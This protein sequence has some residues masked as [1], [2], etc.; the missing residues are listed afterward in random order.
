MWISKQAF[1]KKSPQCA[2]N[3]RGPQEILIELDPAV[4][5]SHLSARAD[6]VDE[7]EVMG[8]PLLRW[9]AENDHRCLTVS[10]QLGALDGRDLTAADADGEAVRALIQT[11]HVPLE[12]ETYD[13]RVLVEI[14]LLFEASLRDVLWV[15]NSLEEPAFVVFRANPLGF[16]DPVYNGGSSD[17]VESF[18]SYLGGLLPGKYF[19]V[20]VPDCVANWLTFFVDGE[21]ARLVG[22]YH[23]RVAALLLACQRSSG[24]GDYRV[25]CDSEAKDRRSYLVQNGRV[26]HLD[27]AG[28]QGINFSSW[29]D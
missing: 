5:R 6:V 21:R 24:G 8:A 9:Y 23:D 20:G 17:E 25:V 4:L 18:M 1:V 11:W 2:R 3:S 16:E 26:S 19:R 12:V 10:V 22:R 14:E 13:W 15:G 7:D 28:H 27:L 29:D